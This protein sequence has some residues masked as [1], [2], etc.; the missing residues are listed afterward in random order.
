[1]LAAFQTIHGP[2]ELFNFCLLNLLTAPEL[3]Q[4]FG[5]AVGGRGERSPQ[6]GQLAQLCF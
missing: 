1:M 3:G 2:L 4:L 5:H 6:A